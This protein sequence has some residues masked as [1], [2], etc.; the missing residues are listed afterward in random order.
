LEYKYNL[1][2]NT[3]SLI[4][5]YYGFP[6]DELGKP[7]DEDRPICKQCFKTVPAKNGH[8]SNLYQHLQYQH[9]HLASEVKQ[10]YEVCAKMFQVCFL[11]F[12]TYSFMF[13]LF[14]NDEDGSARQV[15]ALNRALAECICLNQ[16]PVHIVETAGFRDL[17][18]K[19]NSSYKP[20]GPDFFMTTE[21]PQLYAEARLAMRAQLSKVCHYSCSAE[22]KGSV[23]AMDVCMVITVQW[24]SDNWQMQSWCLG[25][26]ALNSEFSS[27]TLREVLDEMVQEQWSLD[28]SKMTGITTHYGTNYRK[29]FSGYNWVPSFRHNLDVAVYKAVNMDRVAGSLSRIRKTVSAFTRSAKMAKLLL[30]R[31]EELGLPQQPLVHDEPTHW[32][33]TFDMVGRFIE[34]RRAVCALLDDLPDKSQ[35]LPKES[36]FTALETFH[37]ILSPLRGLSDLLSGEKDPMLSSV[38][39]LS[40]KILSC[41][42]LSDED[43]VLARDMKEKISGELKS[44]YKNRELQ[45]LLNTGTFLDPRFKDTFVIMQNDVK[46]TL[47]EKAKAIDFEYPPQTSCDPKEKFEEGPDPKRAKM[48]MKGFLSSIKTEKKAGVTEVAAAVGNHKLQKEIEAYC[49]MEEIGAEEDPLAWWRQNGSSL[50]LL[51]QCAQRYLCIMASASQHSDFACSSKRRGVSEENKALIDFLE[52][53]FVY[54]SIRLV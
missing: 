53:F 34:Q 37:E 32:S 36:E 5:N 50:P 12:K 27:E 4:W 41:L 2:E 19:L 8:T 45:I 28:L 3:R 6:P 29:A 54:S 7:L 30:A 14:V 13:P 31:Q 46:E 47:L 25:S 17:V 51:S 18:L 52:R 1:N 39:P 33:S 40:W 9:P 22:L 15:Q 48:D 35:L 44:R 10:H 42:C 38:L 43:S 21:I 24:I 16:L 23:G 26:A 20:P 49:H 11:S